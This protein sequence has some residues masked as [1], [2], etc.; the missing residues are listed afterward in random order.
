MMT[1]PVVL[2]AATREVSEK[3]VLSSR[4]IRLALELALT[5]RIVRSS[6]YLVP[7]ISVLLTVAAAAAAQQ[8]VPHHGRFFEMAEANDLAATLVAYCSRGEMDSSRLLNDTFK[9][10]ASEGLT[11]NDGDR[12]YNLLIGAANFLTHNVRGEPWMTQVLDQVYGLRLNF[13]P[14]LGVLQ[15]VFSWFVPRRFVA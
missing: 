4:A 12:V 5:Q 2:A 1:K 14:R 3:Y 15:S 9:F 6:P 7:K 10:V 11:G 8:N 13:M